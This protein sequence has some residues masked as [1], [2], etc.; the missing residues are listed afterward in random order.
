MENDNNTPICLKKAFDT[1]DQNIMCEK[2]IHYGIQHREI[3]WF[4]SY[5]SKKR[6]FY[7]IGRVDSE[8][9]YVKV[10]VPQSSCLQG[11]I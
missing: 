4:R 10:G 7:R 1:V 9:N 11:R 8:V 6:Q 5:L 3:E 2:L